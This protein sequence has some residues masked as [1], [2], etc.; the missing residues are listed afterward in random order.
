M[1]KRFNDFYNL[2]DDFI[3]DGDID[4]GDYAAGLGGG[5]FNLQDGFG[6]DEADMGDNNMDP[7]QRTTFGDGDEEMLDEEQI[8][9]KEEK[10]YQ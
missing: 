4:D 3:D 1:D 2:D 10:M 8:A 7:D 6:M 9:E 5:G